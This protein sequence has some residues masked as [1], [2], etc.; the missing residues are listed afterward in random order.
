[1]TD[2]RVM[3]AGA[4]GL[5]GGCFFETAL[6]DSD[7]S[8]IVLLGRRSLP[9][10]DAHEKVATLTTDFSGLETLAPSCEVDAVV[11]ALGT[12][13]KK[14]GSKERLFE[15]DCLYTEAAASYARRCG[16]RTLVVVSSV[17]AS[18]AASSHYLHTKGEM[19]KRVQSMG[20]EACHILRPSLLMGDRKEKRFGEALGVRLLS[21]LSFLMP[22]KYR[23]IHAD[24]LA[25][26][27]DA[28]LKNPGEGVVVHQGASLFQV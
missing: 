26:K 25:R 18:P 1:M 21:P 8:E 12:T 24:T 22:A 9:E 6:D 15:I 4:T 16:A 3:I 5:V 20:F 19:E 27:I 28:L 23:P 14:A 11:C 7:Y 10:L 2:T 17:G 13:I